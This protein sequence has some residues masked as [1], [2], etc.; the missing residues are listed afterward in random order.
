M[1]VWQYDSMMVWQYDSM[2]IGQYDGM[3]VYDS[4]WVWQYDSMTL[5]QYDGMTV[6]DS[7]TVNH[8][9][10]QDSNPQ[11]ILWYYPITSFCVLAISFLS[12]FRFIVFCGSKCEIWTN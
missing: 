1:T 5:W 7:M 6:Y 10:Y 3:T 9:K 11:I 4:R 8:L 12:M 2:T